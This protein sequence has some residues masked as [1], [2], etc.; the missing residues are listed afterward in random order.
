MEEKLP[1]AGNI[2]TSEEHIYSYDTDK[3][4][5][6]VPN[7]P[8]RKNFKIA[9]IVLGAVGIYLLLFSIF[10]VFRGGFSGANFNDLNANC[11]YGKYKKLLNFI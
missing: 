1:L 11:R 4:K 9:C 6:S 5:R 8:G 3:N 2:V 7:T 10:L